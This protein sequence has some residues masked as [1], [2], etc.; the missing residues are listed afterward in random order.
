MIF[1]EKDCTNSKIKQKSYPKWFLKVTSE[2][3]KKLLKKFTNNSGYIK[4]WHFPVGVREKILKSDLS[5][6]LS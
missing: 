3:R 1:Q 4:M 6:Y 2:E 5:I